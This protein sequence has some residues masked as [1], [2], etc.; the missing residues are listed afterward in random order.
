[1]DNITN[2]ALIA[3]M[4]ESAERNIQSAKQLLRE[5]MGGSAPTNGDFAKKAQ[6]LSVSEGG[7]VIEG[8]FDGQN[9]VGPDTKQYPVPANYASKSKLVEGD[10]LKLTIAEDGSFIYKQIG[11]VERR[12]I[13]GTLVADDKGEYKVVAEGKPYKVLLASLTYFK[14]EPGDQVTIVLPKDKDANWGAVENVIKAGA[15]PATMSA[16][17]RSMSSDETELEEL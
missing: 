3:Q 11:P 12:K 2:I 7:K 1:M 16:S 9:M 17:S 6:V 5:I 8:V 4:I 15:A 13:L 14:S 10:V